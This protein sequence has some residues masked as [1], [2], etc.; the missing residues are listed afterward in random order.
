MKNNIIVQISEGLGN[1]LFMYA[2]AY[3]LSQKLGKE[4]L[5]DNTSGYYKDKNLLRPHQK[6]MLNFFQIDNNLAPSNYRYDNF[7]KNILKKVF[8]FFDQF[9][10]NKKF[11]I[12]P[13]DKVNG[14]KIA[15]NYILDNIKFNK[16]FYINGNFENISY[17]RQYRGD[18]IK[19]FTPKKDFINEN[20]LIISK[21]KESNSVSIHIRRNRYSDQKNFNNQNNKIKSEKFTNDIL[22]YI[23]RAIEYFKKEINN[24][25]FFIWSNDFT[26][27]DKI[28][29]KLDINNFELIK[30]NDPINDF[31][32]FKFAKHFIVGP[33]SYHW[34]GAWLNQYKNKICL[35]PYNINPSNNEKFWPDNWIKI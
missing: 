24:P 13:I 30:N 25:N 2:H 7:T 20:K 5:I 35:R 32:L 17:F 27:F 23:N 14:K 34:W 28:T 6:Y 15:R 31:Y 10:K 16:N 26:N 18:L 4:L 1:Q 19:L 29:N 11:I 21:L 8:I 9:N 33:S 22:Q 12:E 3:A